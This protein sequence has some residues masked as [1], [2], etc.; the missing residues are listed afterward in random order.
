MN[1]CSDIKKYIQKVGKCGKL[2][3]GGK[4]KTRQKNRTFVKGEL[5]GFGRLKE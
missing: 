2:T 3:K 1:V 5:L 4:D